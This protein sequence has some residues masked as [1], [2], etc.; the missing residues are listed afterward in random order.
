MDWS[1]DL[2]WRSGGGTR[3]DSWGAQVT[4]LGACWEGVF[5]DFYTCLSMLGDTFET[6]F[7]GVWVTLGS[8]RGHFFIIFG[9]SWEVSGSGLGMFL[10]R[11]GKV[12]E[13]MSGGVRKVNFQK[14]PGVFSL[15]RGAS[16]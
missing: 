10:D 16:E 7:G 11:F 12:L 3:F 6:H 8:G 1:V 14:L 2:V 9:M 15:S 4:F 5:F 13:K